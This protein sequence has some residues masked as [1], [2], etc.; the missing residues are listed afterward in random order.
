MKKT[1]KE[2]VLKSRKKHGDKYGYPEKYL[3]SEV[4]IG[5]LCPVHGL[6]KK[7]PHNHYKGQ[8]CPD[9]SYLEKFDT[10]EEFIVKAIK[11]HGDIFDYSNINYVDAN[12]KV[13]IICKKGHVFSMKPKDHTH[14]NGC[15]QCCGRQLSRDLYIEKANLVHDNRYDYT[16]TIYPIEVLK[17]RIDCPI[18]GKFFLRPAMHLQGRGCQKCSKHGFKSDQP[19]IRY[20]FKDLETGFYKA[21]VTNNSVPKRFWG[22]KKRIEIL[23]ILEFDSGETALESEQ[24]LFEEYA[25]WRIIN[26]EWPEDQGG[27]TEFFSKDI[28]NLDKGLTYE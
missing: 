15:D 12:T 4:P 13:N 19:A 20:Y 16:N 17:I 28:L 14:G 24:N 11:K 18:H 27:K 7:A 21:G 6:F 3:G 26:E 5:I 10:K 1:H 22:M 2:Y 9:C 23:E 25:E 8:G